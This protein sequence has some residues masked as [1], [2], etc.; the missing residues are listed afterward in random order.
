M[1]L[2]KILKD[3]QLWQNGRG[4]KRADLRGADLSW[5]DLS[6]ADFRRAIFYRTNL[7]G[8]DLWGADLGGADLRG[9][10]LYEADLGR[11]D[12]RGTDLS[13]ANLHEVNFRGAK[14]SNCT[15]KSLK[16]SIQRSDGYAFFLWDTEQGWRVDAGCRW[17]TFEEADRHWKSTRLGTSLGGETFDILRFFKAMAKR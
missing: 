16:A 7:S 5:T 4:G 6:R 1:N 2:K 10:D 3:H 15:L 14:R 8:A 9:A 17:F 11:A 13:T 12:L